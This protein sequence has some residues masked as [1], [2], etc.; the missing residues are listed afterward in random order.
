MIKIVFVIGGISGIGLVIV[1]KFL[2]EGFVVIVFNFKDGGYIVE[3]QVFGDYIFKEGDVID[4]KW[5]EEI[6]V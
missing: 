1:K 5:V 3:L 2:N 6:I 4:V